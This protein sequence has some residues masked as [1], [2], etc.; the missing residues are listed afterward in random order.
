MIDLINE[1]EEESEM[2]FLELLVRGGT[3]ALKLINSIIRLFMCFIFF[4][5]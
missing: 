4:F 2:D 3:E 1:G 5:S